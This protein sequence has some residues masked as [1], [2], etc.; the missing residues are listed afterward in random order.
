MKADN[1]KAC[2]ITVKRDATYD[3]KTINLLYTYE[4]WPLHPS[5]NTTRTN[6]TQKTYVQSKNKA[7][8]KVKSPP[9][10]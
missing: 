8:P 2:Y 5:I 10:L 7:H 1:N 4:K 9:W 3:P 6:P